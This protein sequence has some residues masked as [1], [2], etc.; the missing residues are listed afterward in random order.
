[1]VGQAYRVEMK[2]I[3]KAFDGINALS[4]VHLQ[5]KP[6]EIHALMGEN[7]AG[8]S[9]LIK[10]LSGAYIKD[11]GEIFLDG[12][13]VEITNP[14]DG[15]DAGIA[16]IYQEFALVPHLT[17]AENIF[18]DH[19][20]RGKKIIDWKGLRKSARKIL[21]ELGFQDIS[22]KS[23]VSELSIAYQQIVEIVKALSKNARVIVFD[24]PTA[25]LT[26]KEVVQLFR[27]IREL[28]E[29]K[30]VSII[31]VSHRLEEIFELCDRVTVLKDGT[32]VETVN[33][34]DIQKEQL[35]SLMIGREMKGYFPERHATIGQEVFCVNGI[36]N[37][38]MVQ[39]ISFSV[40]SGEILGFGGLVGAGRTE[41]MR[42]IVGADKKGSG[43]IK[44]KNKKIK[45]NTPRDAYKNKVGFLPEDR[46]NQGVL[47]ELPIRY[48]TTMSCLDNYTGPFNKLNTKAEIMDV[49]ELTKMMNLKCAT[50]NAQVKSLSGGNQQKVAVSKLLASK[51]EVLIFDEPTRGV[52]V[53]AKREIYSL[54]NTLA[55][56]GKA[57]IIVSSEM[58]ELIGMCDRIMVMRNG[59]IVG[60]LTGNELE[61]NK[62]IK[63][64]MGVNE[65]ESA[66]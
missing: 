39:N 31:Y 29:K 26:N 11:S 47:L 60:E 10:I 22:E 36:N 49:T 50:I 14:K 38:K 54:I 44:I 32:F 2:N 24:E 21:D 53:G 30:N 33:I 9:T 48:N 27:L 3:Y 28:K 37:G 12:E 42:A 40:R 5:I 4:D 51:C 19:L 8:K 34:E 1:M 56:Q 45:I 6:G 59:K 55:E 17:V 23:I 18:I 15:S 64:A 7:G 61:E 52:D 41:T 20:G 35:V 46:K 25:L 58:T 62:I 13:R 66:K 16:V 43:I 65:N 57:V 63:L